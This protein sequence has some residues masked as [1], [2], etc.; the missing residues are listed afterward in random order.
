MKLLTEYLDRAV[1]FENLAA[2][3]TDP[4]F[5]EH[6]KIKLR[7]IVNLRPRERRS[8]D[9]RRPVRQKILADAPTKHP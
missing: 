7:R 6:L 9:C 4:K 1:Q 8:L 3:E 5:K 2:A